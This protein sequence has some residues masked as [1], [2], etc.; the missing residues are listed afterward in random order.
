MNLGVLARQAEKLIA[1]NSPTILTAI[2][3]TGSVTA[4]YLTG[5][6]TFKAADLIREHNHELDISDQWMAPKEKFRLIWKLYIPAAGTLVLTGAA[7]IC[8]NRIG[9]RRAAALAT[10]YTFSERAF[11]EYKDKVVETIGANKEQKVR[12]E[13]AQDRV[14]ANPP[15]SS[16]VVV[17]AGDVLCQEAL[18]GRYFISSMETL[19]KAQNDTNYQ[20]MRETYA[21]LSDF[22]YRIGLPPTA[23]SD[24]MGWNSDMKL[25]ELKFSTAISED[26]R[27]VLVFDFE[28]VPIRYDFRQN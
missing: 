9:A 26:Q 8:A 27:P 2:G 13:I 10:A 25:L 11:A 18:T 1:D 17:V 12:D 5:T 16:Q 15:S 3:V 21:A 22:Y 4:A 23:Q 20:I 24:N 19:K 6:A 28:V 14:T 7:I